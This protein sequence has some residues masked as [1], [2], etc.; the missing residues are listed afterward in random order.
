MSDGDG[1]G[2]RPGAAYSRRHFDYAYL[3][4]LVAK[5]VSAIIRAKNLLI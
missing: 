1:Q 2:V 4:F 3:I 5:G